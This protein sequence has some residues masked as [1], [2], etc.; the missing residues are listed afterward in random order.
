VADPELSGAATGALARL[1]E[2][3]A[4]LARLRA[5]YDQL[6]NAFKL[7][8][9]APLSRRSTRRNASVPRSSKTRRRSLP[10]NRRR[11]R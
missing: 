6:M 7:T 3:E 10:R 1:A 9:R 5:H 4:E 8:P 11:T 2:L